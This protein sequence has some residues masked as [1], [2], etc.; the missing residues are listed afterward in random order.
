MPL[1]LHLVRSGLRK[2]EH[3]TEHSKRVRKSI[4]MANGF[5]KTQG[6][7][8]PFTQEGNQTGPTNHNLY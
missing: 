5:V 4:K 3:P 7:L 1:S 6:T 8:L 2:V